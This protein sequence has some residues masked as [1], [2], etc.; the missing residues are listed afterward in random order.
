MLTAEFNGK[1]V[2]ASKKLLH[3]SKLL[4][5]QKYLCRN[6]DCKHPEMILRKGDK[7]VPHFAHKVQNLECMQMYEGETQEH[8]A[9]KKFMKELL[10]IPEK[11]VEVYGFEG[12]RPDLLW[13]YSGK[14]YAIEVQHSNIPIKEIQRRN[15]C[16]KDYD[17]IPLWIFH[18]EEQSGEFS[19][20]FIKT[21]KKLDEFAVF[22]PPCIRQIYYL[23]LNPVPKLWERVSTQKT[24]NHLEITTK[25][26]LYEHIINPHKNY[27]EKVLFP[28][29]Q[30]QIFHYLHNL[31][32]S[33]KQSDNNAIHDIEEFP[34]IFKNSIPDIIWKS[35][36]NQKYAFII[37]FV[38]YKEPDLKEY[39]QANIIPILIWESNRFF[40]EMRNKSKL[41]YFIRY[42]HPILLVNIWGYGQDFRI[43][44]NNY[45]II[46][47]LADS[48]DIMISSMIN[49]QNKENKDKIPSCRDCIHFS[50]DLTCK[51]TQFR[52]KP[53]KFQIDH[54]LFDFKNDEGFYFKKYYYRPKDKKKTSS[55]IIIIPDNR[56]FHSIDEAKF[57]SKIFKPKFILCDLYNS[58]HLPMNLNHTVCKWCGNTHDILTEPQFY[59]RRDSY[60]SKILKYPLFLCKTCFRYFSKYEKLCSFCRLRYHKVKYSRCWTCNQSKEV[61]QETK[62][63]GIRFETKE[64]PPTKELAPF[65]DKNRMEYTF[66]QEVN[67]SITLKGD[68]KDPNE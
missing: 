30:T 17:L 14:K 48:P 67:G 23:Q 39:Q 5:T 68:S 56:L 57:K 41:G 46:E 12:V 10:Q 19:F 28:R 35:K 24:K 53:E 8:L 25:E 43:E 60:M 59:L 16:Y 42:S 66:V 9:M 15:Q 32:L 27:Q 36:N 51:I 38:P 11:C 40:Q 22:F 29:K 64:E 21:P 58:N 44:I 50:K 4:H 49:A 3:A 63:L 31:L 54:P 65:Q 13:E 33:T 34:L 20:S 18:Y 62:D 52:L 45:K 1:I 7:K 26:Q 2:E 55:S 6:P 47:S 61:Y 37:I